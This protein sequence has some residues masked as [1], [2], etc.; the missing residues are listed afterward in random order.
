MG[1]TRRPDLLQMKV[2]LERQGIILKYLNNQ[3]FPQ[4]DLVGSYGQ[5]GTGADYNDA[6]SGIRKGDSPFYTYG[7][8][9]SIPLTGNRSARE[10]Y[11]AGKAE[12]DQSLLRLK[13]LEQEIM[14]QIGVAM[15]TAQTTFAQVEK[16]R[17]SRAFAESALEA[18]QKKLE[19][20][21]S[22]S[23]VVVQLQKDLTAA[24]LAEL[25]ALGEYNKAL[26][27]LALRTG[28]ILDRNNLALEIK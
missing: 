14:V 16:T 9:L 20:G 2:D 24:K 26:A 19:N 4:L 6:L 28:T 21:K 11:R 15:E 5:A 27:A 17:Q 12:M 22:T 18:E 1:L 7:A 25:A 13:E 3:R 10:R 8:G 23:F